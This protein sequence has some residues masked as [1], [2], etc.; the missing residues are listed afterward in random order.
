MENLEPTLT[1]AGV[2]V[3][4][5]GAGADYWRMSSR[6][7]AGCREAETAGRSAVDSFDVRLNVIA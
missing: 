4:R 6:T 5:T 7:S 3:S 1:A 2:L